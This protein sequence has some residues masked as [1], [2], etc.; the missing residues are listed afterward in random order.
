MF[1]ICC[2]TNILFMKLLKNLFLSLS[3]LISVSFISAD[4]TVYVCDSSTSVAYHQ[5]KNC[6]GLNRCTHEIITV[7]KTKAID[8]YGKRACKICY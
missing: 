3:L 6:S 7:T 5:K 1:Y 2:W 8:T 4:E